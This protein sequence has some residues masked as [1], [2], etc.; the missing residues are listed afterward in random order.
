MGGSKRWFITLW[1]IIVVLLVI[2]G[3]LIIRHQLVHHDLRTS[4]RSKSKAGA[5][6]TASRLY[7]YTQSA[8]AN[9]LLVAKL[10]PM[11]F[12]GTAIIVQN[13][14]V[15]GQYSHGMA[16]DGKGVKNS[17]NV[18]YE[19]DSVQKNLTAALVMRTIRSGK[20]SFNSHLSDFYPQIPGSQDIT[21]RQMLDMTSGLSAPDALPDQKKQ[22]SDAAVIQ[23]A[24][25]SLHYNAAQ[26]GKW[27]YQPVNFTL[28]AGI[29]TLVT[30]KSYADLFM[31][32]LAR[33]LGLKGTHMAYANMTGQSSAQG[34]NPTTPE[35][36]SQ[37]FDA[38]KSQIQNELGTGQV[39]M[40][41]GDLYRVESSLLNGKLLSAGEA[42]ALYG[43]RDNV[44]Y[45]GGYYHDDTSY[46][47]ANG[48]GYGYEAFVRIT[49]DGKDAVIVM[50]N[51]GAPYNQMKAAVDGVVQWWL[52]QKHDGDV[53]K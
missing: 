36:Y 51:T 49:P 3:A 19:I 42:Q 6:P 25:H 13:G 21:I 33:P 10:K 28:L 11:S 38:T 50:C 22:L 35:N 47:Y 8:A 24:I 46:L 26:R 15:V 41:P 45:S 39:F 20:L 43:P 4:Q 32:T 5:Q 14:H 23:L 7:G 27:A 37:P 17:P 52:V 48:S 53:I 2:D 12:S 29:L 9:Q 44:N 31:Q 40:T 16:D 1:S 30:H 34:Y 18:S